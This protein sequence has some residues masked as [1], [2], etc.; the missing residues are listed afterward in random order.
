M[1]NDYTSIKNYLKSWFEK[2]INDSINE[3]QCNKNFF[4]ESWI[5]SFEIIVLIEDVEKYFS[6]ELGE[7]QFED[8]RIS[9][10]NGLAE[11]IFE[12]KQRKN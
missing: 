11:L 8:R 5:D 10:I 12:E 4:V 3:E 9:Y 2:K 7:K 1:N 6:I